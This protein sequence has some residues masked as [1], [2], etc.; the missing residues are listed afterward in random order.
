[1]PY[2]PA[3]EE[4]LAETVR[5]VEET[6][7]RIVASVIDTRDFD[8]LRVAVD[9]GVAALGRLDVIVAD[10]G[11]SAPQAWNEIT[12][13]DFRDAMVFNVGARGTRRVAPRDRRGNP[14]RP[15]FDTVLRRP[16]E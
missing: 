6:N 3:T 1:M 4:D 5:L 14:G 11:I 13:E 2:P 8:G 10:A 16:R 9:D 12:P 7:R 15:E